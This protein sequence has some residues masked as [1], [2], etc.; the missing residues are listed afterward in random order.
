MGSPFD[1][2]TANRRSKDEVEANARMSGSPRSRQKLPSCRHFEST[3][4]PE[5]TATRPPSWRSS[6]WTRAI[7]APSRFSRNVPSRSG[8]LS[9]A[10]SCAADAVQPELLPPNPARNPAASLASAAWNLLL[11]II[12]PPYLRTPSPGRQGQGPGTGQR[13]RP[14]NKDRADPPFE[15]DA[16][17]LDSG[18]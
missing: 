8:C 4:T 15:K 16:V 6:T 14:D 10:R 5:N 11:V 12:T 3:S 7:M 9:A 18:A 17:L 2:A 13:N 1:S